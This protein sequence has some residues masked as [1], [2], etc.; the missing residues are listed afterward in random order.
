MP[1]AN[2]AS[3]ESFC[4]PS[5]VKPASDTG[6][7][8]TKSKTGP[9]ARTL[10]QS[11]AVTNT[12]C[13]EHTDHP[14]TKGERQTAEQTATTDPNQPNEEPAMTALLQIVLPESLACD[15]EHCTERARRRCAL[16]R[17]LICIA[18]SHPGTPRIDTSYVCNPDCLRRSKDDH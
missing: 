14:T 10:C 7:G 16:C 15:Y 5:S 17:L 4:D 1:H 3:R 12:A 9:K 6:V 18:H 8:T 13:N 2:P 11:R